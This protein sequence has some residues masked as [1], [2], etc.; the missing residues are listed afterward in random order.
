MW[1]V[2]L[3]NSTFASFIVTEYVP[4]AFWMVSGEAT[5]FMHVSPATGLMSTKIGVEYQTIV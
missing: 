2:T 4:V 3:Q 1:Y 5:D